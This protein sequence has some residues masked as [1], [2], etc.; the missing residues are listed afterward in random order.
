MI[1]FVPAKLECDSFRMAELNG[2]SFSVP[3]D[4]KTVSMDNDGTVLG[5]TDRQPVLCWKEYWFSDPDDIIDLGM[6]K[7]ILLGNFTDTEKKT[8]KPVMVNVA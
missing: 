7:T 4:V 6:H 1:R 8:L 3:S 5:W 2:V